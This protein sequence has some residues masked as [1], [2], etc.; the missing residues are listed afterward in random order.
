[1]VYVDHLLAIDVYI[2]LIQLFVHVS[3]HSHPT[4]KHHH[5]ILLRASF[6]ISTQSCQ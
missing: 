6:P 4:K 3:G 2:S 5:D 1:M